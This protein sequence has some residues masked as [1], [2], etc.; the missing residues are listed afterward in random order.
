MRAREALATY[1]PDP[2]VQR[3]A[4]ELSTGSGTIAFH[5]DFL[6]SFLWLFL[7]FPLVFHWFSI[8]S[9]VFHLFSPWQA[10]LTARPGRSLFDLEASFDLRSCSG[11]RSKAKG[12]WWPGIG[13][14]LL[15]GG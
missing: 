2:L 4:R 12:Q 14:N 6:S 11:A 13:S 10:L 1:G 9:L 5:L 7:G 3:Q 8:G 15:P